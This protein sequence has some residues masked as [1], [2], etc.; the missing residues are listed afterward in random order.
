MPNIVWRYL[1][2]ADIR[3]KNNACTVAQARSAAIAAE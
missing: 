2:N 1:F 3:Q